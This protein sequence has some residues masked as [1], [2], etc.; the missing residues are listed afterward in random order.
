VI[1]CLRASLLRFDPTTRVPRALEPMLPCKIGS[2]VPSKKGFRDSG[3]QPAAI[4]ST[5]IA[6]PPLVDAVYGRYRVLSQLTETTVPVPWW[7]AFGLYPRSVAT[8][9]IFGISPEMTLPDLVIELATITVMVEGTVAGGDVLLPGP[10]F[11]VPPQAGG[12]VL[13]IL[14]KPLN[15]LGAWPPLRGFSF[16]QWAPQNITGW[17]TIA[18]LSPTTK[19]PP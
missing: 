4:L 3:P 11:H 1:Q 5:N 12:F 2:W 16:A 8:I 7:P 10:P 17:P 19:L 18:F 15:F 13:V 9:A 14:A 6:L